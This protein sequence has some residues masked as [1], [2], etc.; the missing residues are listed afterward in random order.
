LIKKQKADPAD[1]SI[2]T[3]YQSL[4]EKGQEWSTKMSEISSEFGVEQLAR[5]QEIQGKIAKAAY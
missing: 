3:E 2:M 5:M 4:M 1:R